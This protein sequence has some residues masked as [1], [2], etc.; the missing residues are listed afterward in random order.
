MN[1]SF[2]S[3]GIQAQGRTTILRLNYR[4]TL[5]VLSV[6]Q[7][8]ADELLAE[9]GAEDDN[10]PTIAPE[11]AGRRGPWPEL[12]R[13]DSERAEWECV[14]ARVFDEIDHGRALHDVAILY[15]TTAQAH[16]LEEVLRGKGLP[17]AS[18]ASSRGK[19]A[20][21]DDAEAVKLVSMHSS[22]G[23]EFGCVIIPCLGDMPRP[24]ESEAD[25]AR[26][27]YVAMTR[28]TDKLIMTYR[29]HSVFSRRI[30][31]SLN[32]VQEELQRKGGAPA[33]DPSAGDGAADATAQTAVGA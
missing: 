14:L 2:A 10:I 26:L 18:T 32:A 12:I 30:Q 25:E 16:K 19:A 21:Y 28:A 4:N 31:A 8:F 6:A 15:R 11:S 24:R 7:R 13:C 17:V 9:R 22:K 1:F 27:L 5:E 29:E 20:L 23:L 33:N 3:V